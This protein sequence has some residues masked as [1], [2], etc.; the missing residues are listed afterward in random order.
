M[1]HHLRFIPAL[2]AAVTL[3]AG[4][5]AWAAPPAGVPAGPPAGV[6]THGMPSTLPPVTV[7]RPVTPP[8]PQSAP[9]PVGAPSPGTA[10]D[11]DRGRSDGRGQTDAT[12]HGRMTVGRVAAFSGTTLTLTL[13]TGVT[14]TFTVDAHAYG[15]LKPQVGQNLA[16]SSSDGTHVGA[17][18]A[19]DQTIRGTV[20]SVTRDTVTLML[21]NGRSQT[22]SVASQAA[23]RMNLTPGTKVTIVSHD[24]GQSAAHIGINH[25]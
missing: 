10:P 5:S 23:T 19:A 21:P 20:S 7:P 4:G 15:Q 3:S 6:P 25:H 1:K 17:A 24:G 12:T 13:P 2:A 8:Q 14:K 22:I 16:V 9:Q 18:V 11:T